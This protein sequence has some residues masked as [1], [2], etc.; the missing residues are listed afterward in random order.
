MHTE[1]LGPDTL[2]VATKAIFAPDLSAEDVSRIIDES[3]AAMR[4]AVPSARFIFI[5]PDMQ[6]LAR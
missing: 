6:R 2:L 4:A 3:E 1:H 5:E